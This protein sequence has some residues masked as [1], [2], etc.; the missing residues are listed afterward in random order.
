[1]D[2]GYLFVDKIDYEKIGGM[3]K[4]TFQQTDYDV[5]NGRI[6][7]GE[8]DFTNIASSKNGESY[9]KVDGSGNIIEAN[10]RVVKESQEVILGEKKFMAPPGS[11]ISYKD[12]N[13][14]I[15]LPSSNSA[16][17]N[18]FFVKDWG[19]ST[20]DILLK[21]KNFVVKDEAGNNILFSYGDKVHYDGKNYFFAPGDTLN[22]QGVSIVPRDKLIY[23]FDGKMHEGNSISFGDTSFS[24][25]AEENPDIGELL[26]SGKSK[27]YKLKEIDK[28]YYIKGPN[29]YE[30]VNLEDRNF[31]N[32]E[33]KISFTEP[34]SNINFFGSSN[35]LDPNI[36]TIT[37]SGGYIAET[38]KVKLISEGGRVRYLR[39]SQ[40][41]V[42]SREV[43]IVIIQM[44]IIRNLFKLV[45]IQILGWE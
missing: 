30:N 15:L 43:V 12:G 37:C 7:I 13:L 21:G 23:Y 25:L 2:E 33:F 1:L 6:K 4:L 32:R 29:F 8:N 38:G 11:T 10:L 9:I 22:Y 19:N 39:N 18:S 41:D 17:A 14:E 20:K 36:P 27:Y 28:S 40:N 3:S 24:C 45:K 31:G 34:N 42:H 5:P 35:P 44:K 16:T 26:I